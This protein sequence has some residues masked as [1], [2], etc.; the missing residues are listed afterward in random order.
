MD[1]D[2]SATPACDGAFG[3]DDP[4]M[5]VENPL[6]HSEPK[7]R[8]LARVAAPVRAASAT[9]SSSSEAGR[10]ART[11]PKISSWAI[12]M[13]PA[14]PVNTAGST[15]VGAVLCFGLRVMAMQRDWHLPIAR[16]RQPH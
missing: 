8:A 13:S 1:G 11:G 10:T 5:C 2:P 3:V 12:V 4:A 6:G 7:P 14:T 16:P 15:I 9:A